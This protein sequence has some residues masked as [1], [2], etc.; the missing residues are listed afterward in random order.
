MSGKRVNLLDIGCR[1]WAEYG[2]HEHGHKKVNVPAKTGGTVAYFSSELYAINWDAGQQTVEYPNEL[3]VIGM[4]RN[5]TEFED[6][7]ISQAVSSRKVVGPQGGLREFTIFLRN[8]DWITNSAIA[9]SRLEAANIP[10]QVEKLAR[11]KR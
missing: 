3:C 6:T 1:V 4:A 9:E 5:R 11:K 2:R 7:I 8:G 10:I